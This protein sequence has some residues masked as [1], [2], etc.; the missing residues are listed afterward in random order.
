M[1][2]WTPGG[3]ARL[4]AATLRSGTEMSGGDWAVMSF[5]VTLSEPSIPSCQ[6]GALP[7]LLTAQCHVAGRFPPSGPK[8]IIP[9]HDAWLAQCPVNP[10]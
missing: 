5:T 4:V 1:G 10:D 8:A 6:C 3:E 9:A 7:S 2:K